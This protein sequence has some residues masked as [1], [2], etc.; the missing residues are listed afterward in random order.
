MK[1]LN[2]SYEVN[3]SFS[4]PVSEHCFALRILPVT[5][6]EHRAFT[7]PNTVCSEALPCV[8]L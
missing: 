7:P 2:F 4:Q 3:Y 6:E 5:D 1:K 8:G